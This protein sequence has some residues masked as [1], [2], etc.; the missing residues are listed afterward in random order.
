MQFT[1]GIYERPQE[2]VPAPP[3]G[4]GYPKRFVIDYFRAYRPIGGYR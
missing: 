4:S 2:T 1:L 3:G